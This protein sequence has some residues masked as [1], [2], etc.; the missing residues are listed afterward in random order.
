[1]D[2]SNIRDPSWIQVSVQLEIGFELHFITVLG[3]APMAIV[4]CAA[5]S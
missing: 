2:F 5:T 4:T 3:V 1:M